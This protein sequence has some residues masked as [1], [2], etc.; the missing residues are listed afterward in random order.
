MATRTSP[1][2]S[3]SVAVS[4]LGFQYSFRF[5]SANIDSLWSLV[6]CFSFHW[7]EVFILLF[8]PPL[9]RILYTITLTVI[10]PSGTGTSKIG[11]ACTE[12]DSPNLAPVIQLL[13]E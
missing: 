12:G 4:P 11:V 1:C 2:F 10:G 13:L 5:L 6:T 3:P 9:N 8:E 7:Q